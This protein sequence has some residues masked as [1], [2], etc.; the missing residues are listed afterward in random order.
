MELMELEIGPSF[1]PYA[2]NGLFARKSFYQDDGIDE[3]KGELKTVPYY[4]YD[5][6]DKESRRRTF[7]R[8]LERY[9]IDLGAPYP[10][11]R[12]KW[13]NTMFCREGDCKAMMANDT[14]VSNTNAVFSLIGVECAPWIH[15]MCHIRDGEEITVSYGDQYWVKEKELEPHVAEVKKMYAEFTTGKIF[16]VFPSGTRG[17]HP[18][19][20]VTD[21]PSDLRCW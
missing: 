4:F 3:Y 21:D 8:D 12:P 16:K 7:G 1:L 10:P 11:S 15:A 13:Q 18:L 5:N 2:G 20:P 6:K 14:L 17:V 19:C 9:A